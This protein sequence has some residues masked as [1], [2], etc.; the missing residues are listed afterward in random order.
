MKHNKNNHNMPLLL[1]MGI[2]IGIYVWT[3]KKNN[4]NNN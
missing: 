2:L 4:N 1:K 3:I